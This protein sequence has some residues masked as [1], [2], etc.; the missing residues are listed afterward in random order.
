MHA[1]LKAFVENDSVLENLRPSSPHSL[2]CR[3]TYG[4]GAAT[5]ELTRDIG[6]DGGVNEPS[7]R[8]SGLPAEE[9]DHP[10]DEIGLRLEPDSL[11]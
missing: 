7:E 6:E 8:E 11:F 1:K 4:S 2:G 9:S 3:A 5:M 10:R